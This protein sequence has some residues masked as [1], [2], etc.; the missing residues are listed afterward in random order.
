MIGRSFGFVALFAA[1]AA[2]AEARDITGEMAYRERIALDDSAQLV[3]ELRGPTGPVAEARIETGGRQ[4]PLPFTLVAPDGGA[5]TL[6]G[7]IFVGGR[8]EWLSAPMAVPEGEGALD[9]GMVPLMR[10]VA[11]G[12]STQMDC[13]G[14]PVEVGFVDD[15]ARLRVGGETF[16]LKPVPSGSGAKFSDGATPETV[17]WSKGNA[18]MVTLKGADLPECA[19]VIAPSLLPVTLRGNEPGWRLDLSETG[20][21]YTAQSGAEEKGVLPEAVATR[22]GARFDLTPRLSVVV[23][24]AICHDTMTGMPYPMTATLT[25]D[26]TALNGCGGVP[27]DLLAGSWTVDELHG[28]ALPEEAEVTMAFDAAEG[29]VFGKSACNRYNGSFTLS[30]EG[31]SFGPAAG[32]MMACPEE[33]MKVEQTFLRGLETV[34]RFDI[35][36]DGRLELV[37]GDTV[38]LRAR[39]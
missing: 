33:L 11:M 5:Y 4:V 27:T 39:R 15:M 13:G 23:G 2:T 35:G 28:A 38:L 8:A 34:S 37:A 32:T 20:Y 10:H 7:A 17:F 30:G 1:L 9:L 3:I 36:A 14:T 25:A 22:E 16:D 19:P 12:F 18:A 24:R 26:G 29:R 21:I 31:L 6:Q